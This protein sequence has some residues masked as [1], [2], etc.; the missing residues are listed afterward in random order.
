VA[1]WTTLSK[2][3]TTMT[4]FGGFA[5]YNWQWDDAV[6]G[7]ELNYNRVGGSSGGLGS[8]TDTMTRTFND[9][10]AAPTGHHYFYTAS[11]GSSASARL[12]SYGTAR[13]RAG[14]AM[15]KFMPYAFGGFAVGTVD[16]SRSATVAYI[17]R[18]FPDATV[19]PAPPITPQ[20]NFV[21]GPVTQTDQKDSAIAFGYTLGLGIDIALMPNVFLRGEWEYIQFT[22]VKDINISVNTV[23][24][25]VALKF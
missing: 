4:S 10:T 12:T 15:D 2:V 6:L 20:P 17:R 14:Y 23:R 13:V 21:F 24:A 16:V 1:G 3:D 7:V 9:D 5:G 25:G 19:P 22:P 11:V 18:D 8:S